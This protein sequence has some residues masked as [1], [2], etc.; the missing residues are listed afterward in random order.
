MGARL[1]RVVL[2]PSALRN[3]DYAATASFVTRRHAC[4]RSRSRRRR[5][6]FS[7]RRL[8]AARIFLA[9][10]ARSETEHAEQHAEQEERSAWLAHK[11]ILAIHMSKVA[12]K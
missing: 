4:T 9:Q 5:R 6:V 7:R 1:V 3:H 2:C 8:A 11:P 12:Q 10:Q